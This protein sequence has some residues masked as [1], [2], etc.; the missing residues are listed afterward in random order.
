[1]MTFL[2]RPRKVQ[3]ISNGPSTSTPSL[4]S[5]LVLPGP[6]LAS[7]WGVRRNVIPIMRAH[8]MLVTISALRLMIP[9]PPRAP[10]RED[11]RESLHAPP[12]EV[13][14][15]PDFPKIPS[16]YSPLAHDGPE[17]SHVLVDPERPSAMEHPFR[18]TSLSHFS[19]VGPS[20]C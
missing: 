3:I 12:A 11:N 4:A 7:T 2:L 8:S 9:L 16:R 5:I 17:H 1:M 20:G 19:T 18:L 6:W 14:I 13:T 15:I 10:N